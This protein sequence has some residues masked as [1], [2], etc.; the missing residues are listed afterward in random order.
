MKSQP[1]SDLKSRLS[2][3]HELHDKWNPPLGKRP[4]ATDWTNG[5][6]ASIAPQCKHSHGT[7]NRV[8]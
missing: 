2:H 1:I 3:I 4:L 5:A 6:I 7:C 8:L